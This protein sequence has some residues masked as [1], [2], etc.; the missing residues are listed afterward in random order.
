MYVT[1]VGDY[2]RSSVTFPRFALETDFRAELK[3]RQLL[4]VAQIKT[5]VGPD[6][7]QRD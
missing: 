2:F 3:I 5:M 4:E 7:F 6:N 1:D